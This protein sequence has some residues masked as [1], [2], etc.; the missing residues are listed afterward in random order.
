VIGQIEDGDI[1]SVS[2]VF[3]IA[4]ERVLLLDLIP[5]PQRLAKLKEKSKYRDQQDVKWDLI[6]EL[7]IW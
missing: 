1:R 7:S 4:P 2:I 6:M 5:E 3:I